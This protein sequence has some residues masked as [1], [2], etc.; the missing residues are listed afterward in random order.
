[1]EV[2]PNL[3]PA[4]QQKEELQAEEDAAPDVKW[5]DWEGKE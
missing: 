4:K 1:M 5:V 2:Q 3:D